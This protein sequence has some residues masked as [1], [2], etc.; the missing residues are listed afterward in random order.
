MKKTLLE[1]A[2]VFALFVL[3]P[4]FSQIFAYF[5][6][7][8]QASPMLAEYNASV[9]FLA[10]LSFLLVLEFPTRIFHTKPILEEQKRA[11]FIRCLSCAN[12]CF[13]SLC[14]ISAVSLL[15]LHLFNVSAPEQKILPP[16]NALGWINFALGTPCA[17]FSE[18]VIFRLYLP[19]RFS[20]FFEKEND[21]FFSFRR[22]VLECIPLAL[23]SLAHF[24]QGFFGILN[25]FLCA[26]ALRRCFL[27]TRSIF[28]PF[29]VHALYNFCVFALFWLI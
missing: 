29:F 6:D 10:I 13:G 3:N 1:F 19:S 17:A 4:I 21:S 15:F 28:V 25:A 14:L 5:L 7:G 16:K 2:L 11:D 12:I 18:E 26:I 24:Y 27:K 9:F 22:F 23:F 8:V 20:L